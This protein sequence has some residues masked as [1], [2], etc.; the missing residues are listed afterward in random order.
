[1]CLE[2]TEYLPSISIHGSGI[3]CLIPKDIFLSSLSKV[4]TTASTVSPTFMKSCAVRKCCDQL[5]SET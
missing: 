5:I 4:K 1:L 3:N 2:P